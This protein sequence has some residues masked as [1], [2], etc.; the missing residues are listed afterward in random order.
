MTAR[1]FRPCALL[2]VG[3]AASAA[4][5]HVSAQTL[6]AD[7]NTQA[8]SI[9]PTGS[10]PNQ[11]TRTNLGAS[12]F[13]AGG[14]A[15]GTQV[16]RSNGTPGGTY[17][18]TDVRI[19]EGFQPNTLV[20]ANGAVL[21]AATTATGGSR[22]WRTDGTSAG[23]GPL[24]GVVLAGNP[25]LAVFG[26]L[27]LFAG[28]AAP[29][30]QRVWRSDATPGGTF[31]LLPSPTPLNPATFVD[32]GGAIAFFS[33]ATVGQLTDREL[34]R[35]DG[36]SAGTWRV[37]DLEAGNA[38]S[39]PQ[40]LV[41]L[42][43]AVLFAANT[44]TTGIE[45]WRSDG[46]TANTGLVRDIAAGAASS[47]PTLLCRAGARVFFAANDTGTGRELWV[48]DGT[49]AG[50]R[51]VADLEPGAAGSDPRALTAYGSSVVFSAA[52]TASGREPW[53]SDG[54]AAGT[55][56][57]A[58]VEP[59]ASSSDPAQFVAL[60]TRIWFCATS[61]LHGREPW[62]SGGSFATTARIL[63]LR[64][65]ADSGC[66]TTAPI[67]L[68]T[69]EV[70]FAGNDG[71][72]GS[73]PWLSDGTAAGT[74]LLIDVHSTAAGSN[75][76]SPLRFRDKLL[77]YAD[78][79]AGERLW[80]SD[81]T[82]TGTTP[83]LP[84]GVFTF[85]YSVGGPLA[86]GARVWF[87]AHPPYGGPDIDL[88]TTDGTQAG[89][90]VVMSRNLSRAWSNP[91]CLASVGE[92]LFFIT[93]YSPGGALWRSDGTT[94][95][96]TVVKAFPAPAPGSPGLGIPTGW[97]GA[98][99]FAADD[100]ALGNELWRS[101]G[102]LAGTTLFA[103]L[104]PG[105]GSSR[106]RNLTAFGTRLVFT[107]N[108]GIV[109]DEL[110]ISDG[111]A[112]G[113]HLLIDLGPGLEGSVVSDLCVDG[114]RFFFF[115]TAFSQR[116]LFVSDGTP[117]GTLPLRLGVHEPRYLT[118]ADG[119]LFFS[120]TTP[121]AGREP[122]VSDGTPQGTHM[123]TDLR[124]GAA[125]SMGFWSE[126]V[127]AG[128]GPQVVFA[129]DDGNGLGLEP[130]VSD[131]TPQGTWRIADV[132][133]GQMHGDPRAFGRTGTTMLFGANDEFHGVELWSLSLRSF[134]V[135]LADAFGPG[136]AGSNGRSPRLRAEPAPRVGTTSFC[137][138]V[139]DAPP[140]VPTVVLVDLQRGALAAGGG[141]TLY[142][143]YA[144]VQCRIATDTQ[145]VA[146][147]ALP[148]PATQ[149]LVGLELDAQAI[150]IDPGAAW[151]GAFALTNGLLLL[152]GV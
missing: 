55:Q 7:I 130:W 83:L 135:S 119:R 49:A 10:F 149:N 59:G 22:L 84:A 116:G 150:V 148:I 33:A 41:R 70:L 71:R 132:A 63:D 39:Y 107:A 31:A 147:L 151:L 52:T 44:M 90:Q 94:I 137:L 120:A 5:G 34:W 82:P 38:G 54:T 100:P 29:F 125:S 67:A 110:W 111:T 42:G 28:G 72:R 3:F 36:T 105:P 21:F 23:T 144:M 11:F 112:A 16:W 93:G 118:V 45:L 95:G 126:L 77:F 91:C 108:D 75:P 140:N 104:A 145:G 102:T 66:D 86:T 13:V 143:P 142:L 53:I 138:I 96:S 20:D 78:D 60:G 68:P 26:N 85:E 92:Y 80:A 122:W 136:C 43:N 24:A 76:R 50:T 15:R 47:S 114:D 12:L 139:D 4:P 101:D 6:V 103:D 32:A 51:L 124:A 98:C 129:A 128:A 81:G 134:G 88:W 121:A 2:V 89:T 141:C 9:D 57:L 87:T 1:W 61:A 127:A 113:T 14:A 62:L 152:I 97:A 123:V 46:S 40:H 58:D 117:S 30:D 109:G 64:P 27:A 56:I 115:A 25:Q 106:P 19:G 65:G 18:L 17:V 69:G 146:R 133:A 131:G 8:P 48:T 73:E 79:G 35:T 99:W 74:R 37:A